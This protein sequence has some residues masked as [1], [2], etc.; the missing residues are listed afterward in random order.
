MRGLL[1]D[2]LFADLVR[3]LSRQGA[4][5][6]LTITRDGEA[7]E[8]FFESGVPVLA[9]ATVPDEQIECWLVRDGLV[10]AEQIKT[11]WLAARDSLRTLDEVLVQDG[12]VPAATL[13]EA[14]RDGSRRAVNL[15]FQWYTGDYNFD[16]Q[17]CCSPV[18]AKLSWSAAECI[19]KGARHASGNDTILDAIAPDYLIVAPVQEGAEQSATL[20]SVEGY[21]LSCIQSPISVWD[22]SGLTGLPHKET[23]RAV[24]VLILLGLIE[25]QS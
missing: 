22:A 18:A 9:T 6:G 5:G 23:R 8:V 1:G 24:F 21:V 19:L 7:I 12:I 10:S 11:A 20:N 16:P 15:A 2:K 17:S 4:A 14:Q 25:R 13:A 3:D